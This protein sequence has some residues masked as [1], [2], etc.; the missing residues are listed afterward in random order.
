VKKA[1]GA[2]YRSTMAGREQS[3]ERA[4][5]IT[6]PLGASLFATVWAMVIVCKFQLGS[7]LS[8]R[9]VFL[10]PLVCLLLVGGLHAFAVVMMRGVMDRDENVDAWPLIYGTWVPVV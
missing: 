10:F 9:A 2:A 1:R 7:T 6:I 4:S 3:V 8:W 5:S